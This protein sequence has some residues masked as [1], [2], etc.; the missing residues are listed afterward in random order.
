[1]NLADSELHLPL[2]PLPNVVHFP[3]TDL[4]LHIFEPRYRRLIR[5]LLEGPPEQ[6][7]IGMVLIKPGSA[8]PVPEIY[9]SGTAGL[10]IDV[11]LLPDGRSNILLHGDFR[12]EVRSEVGDGPYR[13]AIVSPVTEPAVVEN[14]AG[15]LVLRRGLTELVAALADE[16]GS[17]FP[18]RV[19]RLAE[20]PEELSFEIFINRIAAEI[21][22]PPLAKVSLLHQALPERALALLE[23]LK[24]RKQVL[25]LLRPFRRLANDSSLN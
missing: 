12:F 16:I 2:F 25:D 14:D 10:L 3:G 19:D 8:G 5:D 20:S 24:S 11:D 4:K 21:D 9:P 18:I 17:D 6:R 1:M 23:I 22:L 13:R 15:V 7:F